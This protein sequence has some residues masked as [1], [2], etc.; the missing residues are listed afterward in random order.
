MK[1]LK[2]LSEQS[3]PIQIGILCSE[4]CLGAL[5]EA[6]IPFSTHDYGLI[7]VQDNN[8]QA[9]LNMQKAL[10]LVPGSAEYASD[11]DRLLRRIPDQ[12]VDAL[13]VSLLLRPKP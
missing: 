4:K 10:E 9:A 2:D 1:V 11:L 7:C 8:T 5:L 6:G 3:N 13:Q 12:H